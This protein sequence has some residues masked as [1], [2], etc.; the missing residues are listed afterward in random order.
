[1]RLTAGARDPVIFPSSLIGARDNYTL[2]HHIST[3][4]YLQYE[5]AKVRS[6]PLRCSEGEGVCAAVLQ[7]SWHGRVR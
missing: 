3:T 7:E 5:G 2:L 6:P 4:E 1:M